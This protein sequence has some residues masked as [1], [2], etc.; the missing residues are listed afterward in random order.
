MK[1][2]LPLL[3]VLIILCALTLCCVEKQIG[4]HYT[5]VCYRGLGERRI[6]TTVTGEGSDCPF[7]PPGFIFDSCIVY[8]MEG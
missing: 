4:T 7:C 8:H 5:L 2:F 1:N 3:L 6:E